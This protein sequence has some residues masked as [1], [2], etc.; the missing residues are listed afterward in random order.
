MKQT[1][2]KE[3]KQNMNE[4]KRKATPQSKAWAT[5]AMQGPEFPGSE[6]EMPTLRQ[7]NVA[8]GSDSLTES[9]RFHRFHSWHLESEPWRNCS[10]QMCHYLFV[11][12]HE[13]AW[14]NRKPGKIQSCSKDPSSAANG[15]QMA[16]R[17]FQSGAKTQ[18]YS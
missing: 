10:R 7:G 6:Q 13:V 16:G 15:P 2:Q 5:A 9:P 18:I 4:K 11:E 3:K 12:R 17:S 14:H 8:H 1:V